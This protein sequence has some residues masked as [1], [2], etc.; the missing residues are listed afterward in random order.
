MTDV[1]SRSVNGQIMPGKNIIISGVNILVKGDD[2]SVGIFFT[3]DE[4]DA[5]P[6]KVEYFSRSTNTEQ[7]AEVPESLADGQYFLS[8]T[9]QAGSGY[10][11]LKEPRSYRFPILLT[12]GGSDDGGGTDTPG[13]V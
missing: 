6:M 9:T 8:V 5:Q 13:R 1:R 7:I 2:P 10:K 3:K 11:L 12:V 4:A